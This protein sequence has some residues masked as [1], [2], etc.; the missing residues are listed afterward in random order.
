MLPRTDIK[1]CIALIALG[2]A[3][4]VFADKDTD[5]PAEALPTLNV[6]VNDAA[7]RGEPSFLS[8][9][10][11]TLKYGDKVGVVEEIE[12]WHKVQPEASAVTG[13][14]HVS[15]LTEKTILLQAGETDANV[16]AS[17]QELAAGGRGFN[18]EVEDKF[19]EENKDLDA[20]YR[21]LDALLAAPNGHVTQ[22]EIA[23][24]MREGELAQNGGGQ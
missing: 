21:Q 11:A 10:A 6:Q 23:R 12:D 19:R 22:A 20:A 14:M 13:W 2:A 15:A 5:T 1:V 16:K 4:S 3:V 24:F 8:Q 18:Q 7:V 17:K 9:V